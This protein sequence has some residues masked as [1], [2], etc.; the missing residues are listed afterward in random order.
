M[1]FEILA[2]VLTCPT[3]DFQVK[4]FLNDLL[5]IYLIIFCQSVSESQALRRSYLVYEFIATCLGEGD[6]FFS[7]SC[8][9][10]SCFGTFYPQHDH[11]RVALN[12]MRN[13]IILKSELGS[14]QLQSLNHELS[15]MSGG[16]LAHATAVMKS[17]FNISKDGSDEEG[18]ADFCSDECL[19]DNK[20]LTRRHSSTSSIS[21]SFDEFQGSDGD[22]S[23]DLNGLHSSLKVLAQIIIAEYSLP[24]QILYKIKESTTLQGRL[25]GC[26]STT[27][28]LPSKSTILRN[29]RCN[30][31]KLQEQQ[32][33]KFRMS[34]KMIP[35]N[36]KATTV[37]P[38]CNSLT[39]LRAL[40]RFGRCPLK[41]LRRD[42]HTQNCLLID[43]NTHFEF[44]PTIPPNLPVVSQQHPVVTRFASAE[45]TGMEILQRQQP[46][47]YNRELLSHK[48]PATLLR[49]LLSHK[50][51]LGKTLG[52]S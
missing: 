15:S 11:G 12:L 20:L 9:P 42:Y 51:L 26:R 16:W 10:T 5:R 48:L 39:R 18:E 50:D 40:K 46:I 32:T 23:T 33:T 8:R 2:E 25:R 28:C 36:E 45:T 21:S 27:S 7:T 44:P 6:C 37:H 3:V 14:W 19:V 1:I 38:V 41:P 43:E 13:P 17:A 47:R 35:S 4:R 34:T 52:H 22:T 24:S 29:Y 30:Q 31:S 49:C